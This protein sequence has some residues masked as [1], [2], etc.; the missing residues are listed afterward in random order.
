MIFRLIFLFTERGADES[1]EQGVRAVGT[2]LEFR[3]ELYSDVEVVIFRFYGFHDIIVGR[4][5]AYY[6]A[7]FRE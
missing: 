1:E 7:L 4:S 2:A 3:V 5:A 6:Q